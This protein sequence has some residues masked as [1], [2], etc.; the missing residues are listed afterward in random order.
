[1][2]KVNLLT[3][4]ATA[5]RDFTTTGTIYGNQFSG[6]A[7]TKDGKLTG[8][9]AGGFYGPGAAEVGGAYQ[10]LGSGE[11]AVGGFVGKK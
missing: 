1:M 9:A 6:P 5:W 7:A 2:A 4:A 11:R 8:G 10:M 3:N